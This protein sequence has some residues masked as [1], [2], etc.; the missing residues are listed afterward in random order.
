LTIVSR[1]FRSAEVVEVPDYA[2]RDASRG[3]SILEE[4][5]SNGLRKRK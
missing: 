2:S 5:F 3:S 1:Y 4:A